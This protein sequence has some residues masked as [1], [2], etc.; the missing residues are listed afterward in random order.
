MTSWSAKIRSKVRSI[1][2]VRAASRH[3]PKRRPIAVYELSGTFR[4]VG[5]ITSG[6]PTDNWF[7]SNLDDRFQWI[8]V[9]YEADIYPM[10]ESVA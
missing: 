9:P 10:K 5:D 4:L 1:G 3:L 7:E 2:V 6:V 8:P